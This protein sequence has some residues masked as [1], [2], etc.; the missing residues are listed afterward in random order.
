MHSTE[1]WQETVAVMGLEKFASYTPRHKYEKGTVGAIYMPGS[2]KGLQDTLVPGE[3]AYGDDYVKPMTSGR[4][5]RWRFLDVDGNFV[6]P[7]EPKDFL[8]TVAAHES[9]HCAHDMILTSK[10]LGH[11]LCTIGFLQC[12]EGIGVIN[13]TLVSLRMAQKSGNEEGGN[14]SVRL[15]GEK[16]G[17]AHAH[18]P[19][20]WERRS[21]LSSYDPGLIR[22]ER[23]KLLQMEIPLPMSDKQKAIMLHARDYV[24]K[25]YRLI[26]QNYRYTGYYRDHQAHVFGLVKVILSLQE[27]ASFADLLLNPFRNNEEPHEYLMRLKRKEDLSL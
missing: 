4:T 15:L 14:L 27:G 25:N 3:I 10:K 5:Q 6:L 24:I 7:Y 12:V 8:T 21:E 11:F 19:Y 9:T 20:S 26:A 23:D 22:V 2:I 18:L 17:L 13:E 1:I 16:L